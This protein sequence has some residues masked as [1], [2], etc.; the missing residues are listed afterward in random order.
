MKNKQKNLE[1]IDFVTD[2]TLDEQEKVKGGFQLSLGVERNPIPNGQPV[3]RIPFSTFPPPPPEDDEDSIIVIDP[4][5]L[6]N[7]FRII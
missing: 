7:N 5:T 6:L 3:P 2:L 4:N 1:N